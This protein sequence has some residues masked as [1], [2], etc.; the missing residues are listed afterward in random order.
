MVDGVEETAGS[1]ANKG[2]GVTEP[3]TRLNP[4][5]IGLDRPLGLGTQVF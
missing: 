1:T 2:T 5:G 4:H 3:M